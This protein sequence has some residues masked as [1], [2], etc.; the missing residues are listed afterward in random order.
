MSEA[1]QVA[2]ISGAVSVIVGIASALI[3][4]RSAANEVQK[5]LEIAQAVTDTKLEELTREVRRHNDFAE[6]V[7]VLEE[8]IIVANHRIEDLEKAGE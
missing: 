1:V 7:P 4:A 6:R 2:L 8:K 3:A 5:K